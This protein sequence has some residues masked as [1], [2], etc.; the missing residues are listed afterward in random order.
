MTFTSNEMAYQEH[1]VHAKRQLAVAISENAV[2]FDASVDTARETTNLIVNQ[3]YKNIRSTD[4]FEQALLAAQRPTSSESYCTSVPIIEE[5]GM[6]CHLVALS[7]DQPLPIHD[8]PNSIGLLMVITGKLRVRVFDHISSGIAGQMD[9]LVLTRIDDIGKGETGFVSRSR[10][11]LHS[12]ESLSAKTIVL[13][14]HTPSITSREQHYYFPLSK[15]IKLNQQ[16]SVRRLSL[17]AQT[18]AM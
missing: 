18:R 17:G 12:M 6:G 5:P 8:H 7:Q 9:K 14:I 16:F 3:F 13:T 11:N 1:S 2:D 4:L 15:Q 10:D